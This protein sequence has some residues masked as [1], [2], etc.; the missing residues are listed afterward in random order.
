MAFENA[1]LT[2]K[3]KRMFEEACI[4]SP[5]PFAKQPFVPSKWTIDRENMI[6][7]VYAGVEDRTE[8]YWEKTFL[9]FYNE[10]SSDQMVKLILIDRGFSLSEER[11][12]SEQHNVGGVTRWNVCKY[13][14][15][16]NLKR[17]FSEERSLWELLTEILNCYGINGDPDKKYNIKSFLEFG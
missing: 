10:I 17:V 1:Y 5:I 7:F 6:A 4:R 2:E 3:D 13:F 15:P 14:I 8:N 9:L 11:L 16:K 12:L